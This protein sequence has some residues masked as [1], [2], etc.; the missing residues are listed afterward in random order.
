[1]LDDKD[2]MKEMEALCGPESGDW[3][4]MQTTVLGGHKVY[5]IAHRRGGAVRVRNNIRN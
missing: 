4:V 1:M 2:P 5:A 3:A